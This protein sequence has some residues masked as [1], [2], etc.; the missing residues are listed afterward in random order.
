MQAAIC[1]AFTALY[2]I[3]FGKAH[4]TAAHCRDSDH[5]RYE[6]MNEQIDTYSTAPWKTLSCVVK[7]MDIPTIPP[8]LYTQS[9]PPPNGPNSI[10]LALLL[11]EVIYLCMLCIPPLQVSRKIN[12]MVK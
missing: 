1:L 12:N 2:V 10:S 7:S 8:L 6:Y 3:G 9:P 5:M 4:E 11:G